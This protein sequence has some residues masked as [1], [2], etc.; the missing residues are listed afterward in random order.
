MTDWANSDRCRCSLLIKRSGDEKEEEIKALTELTVF[1]SSSLSPRS[2]IGRG[3]K[4][5]S[6]LAHVRSEWINE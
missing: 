1:A 3:Y 5:P 2:L 4:Q 6:P